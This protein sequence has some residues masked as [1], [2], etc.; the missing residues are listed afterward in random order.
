MQ[1]IPMHNHFLLHPTE[2]RHQWK[3]LRKNLTSDLSDEQH[4]KL[5]IDW[6][7]YTPLSERVID[8]TDCSTWPDPWELIDNKD[9]DVNAISLCM[10]YTLLYSSDH[11]WT[12]DRLKLGVVINR[13]YSTEQLVCIVDNKWILGWR[14]GILSNFDNESDLEYRQMYNY[15]SS[16]RQIEETQSWMENNY[17][18]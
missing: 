4:F 5:V 10:F 9:F 18:C 12:T 16:L 1:P 15:N 2:L 3:E 7:K 8:Y 11:R 17:T 14:H 13:K 6:W